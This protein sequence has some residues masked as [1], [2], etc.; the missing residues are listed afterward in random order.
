V[1][2]TSR[3]TSQSANL[4]SEAIDM[5]PTP[6][7]I[8]GVGLENKQSY[9]ILADG[10][11]DTPIDLAQFHRH[12]AAVVTEI[13]KSR[14]YGLAPKVGVWRCDTMLPPSGTQ[15]IGW[16]DTC[17]RAPAT[18]PLTQFEVTF[19][20]NGG[21]CRQLGGN[22]TR[23]QTIRNDL[24]AAGAPPFNRVMTLINT[25]EYGAF[26]EGDLSWSCVKGSVYAKVLLHELGHS[27]RLNDE[28][29]SKCGT[30]DT[31]MPFY[32]RKDF[33]IGSDRTNLPWPMPEG[34]V[35]VMK[36]NTS[37]CHSYKTADNP[38]IGAFQGGDHRHMDYFRPGK[39]CRMRDSSHEFCE[40]CT[41][42]IANELDPDS[43][44][45]PLNM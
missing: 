4:T 9:L 31:L 2:S 40:L 28:Y 42:I 39:R 41:N 35:P 20:K 30:P 19:A 10:Y 12:C 25:T 44:P 3:P 6:V 7:Q 38:P 13:T 8:L 18:L 16:P 32:L 29:E 27:F 5:V 22:G 36:S 17:G 14:W 33:N 15:P 1:S 43:V 37:T 34:V 21:P 45:F 26:C 24:H 23:I 11:R